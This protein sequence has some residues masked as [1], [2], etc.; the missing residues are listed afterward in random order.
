MITFS[1]TLE[2]IDEFNRD[3]ADALRALSDGARSGVAKAVTEGAE[4]GRRTATWKDRTG[5][6]RRTIRGVVKV[7][8][9]GGADG[10]IVA[11]LKYH[12][13]LDSGTKPHLIRPVRARY[14]R[15]VASSGDLVFTKLVHHPGTKG[16]GF[17]GRMY[18]KAERVVT[19]EVEIAAEK[20]AR[21][22]ER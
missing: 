4:E 14:L 20:A 9:P 21:I 19:R 2:G 13:W 15:F 16:D 12:S 7:S 22:M 3:W 11:P 17:A 6:A 18:Q 5:A 8:T 10:E 1:V